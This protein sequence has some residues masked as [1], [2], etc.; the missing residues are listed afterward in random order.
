MPET[1]PDPVVSIIVV[2]YNTREMTLDCL[3]SVAAETTIPYELIVVD[4][5]S[6]DGSAEA[7]AAAHPEVRLIASDE[8]L[9]FGRANNRAAREARGEYV[10][11]LN[12][13]TVTLDGA[14]DK[15]VAFARSMPEAKMW[16]GRT[17]F[18][19]GRLNPQSC[20]ELPSLWNIT[21]RTLGLN[22]LFPKSPLFHSECYPDWER[23]SVREVDM[24]V[25]CFLMVTRDFYEEL[26]GFDEALFM[27]GDDVDLCIRARKLGARPHITPE[28]TIIHY[29]GSS[30]RVRAE[31]M[32]KIMSAKVSVIQ[33]HFT[34]LR[35]PLALG[36]LRMWPFTRMGAWS[37]LA[38]VTRSPR[39]RAGRDSWT[40]IWRRRELWWN[41]Y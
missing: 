30:D 38:A 35:K 16:G 20:W 5:A 6:R 22:A 15:L 19:D 7:I 10:L 11:L 27:Y 1:A 17:I 29:S 3:R 26:G 21:C 9:G 39:F 25:G 41:G 33:R 8:N 40:E 32:V 2:S 36:A 13:D 4:N 14:I 23:D 28:A 34:G 18:P 37:L 24:I 31:R 12:S